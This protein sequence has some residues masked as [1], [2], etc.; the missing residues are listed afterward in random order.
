MNHSYTNLYGYTSK[1]H[2]GTHQTQ[3]V[4][5]SGQEGRRLV[6]GKG[7]CTQG[8]SAVCVMFYFLRAKTRSCSSRDKSLMELSGDYSLGYLEHFS[9]DLKY[10]IRKTKTYSS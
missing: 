1:A 2:L 5:L 7:L 8:L 10:F 4:G 9:A 6:I 3:P